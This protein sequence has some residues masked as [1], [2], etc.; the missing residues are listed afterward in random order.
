M[1]VVVAALI[2][3]L[4]ASEVI[5][6]N[7]VSEPQVRAARAVP[8]ALSFHSLTP[9]PNQLQIRHEYSVDT[10][11]HSHMKLTIDITVAMSCDCAS[12]S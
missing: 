7:T 4:V 11:I 12:S 9:T 8:H 1:T 10:D 5:Y 2:L 6:Y 3:G